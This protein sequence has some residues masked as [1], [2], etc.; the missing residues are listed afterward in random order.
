MAV[1]LG[2]LLAPATHRN[3][4][5]TENQPPAQRQRRLRH[6]EVA[7]LVEDYVRG[8]SVDE[9]IAAHRVN[10]TTVY[11]HLDRNGIQRPT[12]VGKL[13][14]E[15]VRRAAEL[16]KN[17]RAMSAVATEFGVGEET[18]RRTLRRLGVQL[19]GA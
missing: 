8:A 15:Q 12:G 13:S 2:E 4:I 19:L 5:E 17:G 6:D 11:A 9:L 7:L 10:R 16:H 1:D 18:V 3:T 14:P